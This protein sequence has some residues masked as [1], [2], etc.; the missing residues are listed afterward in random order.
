MRVCGSWGTSFRVQI[1]T[2]YIPAGKTHWEAVREALKPTQKPR[3]LAVKS[4]PKSKDS[5]PG[6][7]LGPAIDLGA[8][9]AVGARLL[10]LFALYRADSIGPVGAVSAG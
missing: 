5:F 4:A 7:R 10:V 2:P 3:R 6:R 1:K 9:Q 8:K